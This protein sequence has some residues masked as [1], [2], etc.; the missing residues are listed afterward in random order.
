MN[1]HLRKKSSWTISVDRLV[2]LILS[3]VILGY[4]LVVG[5]IAPYQTDRYYM[6]V[7]PLI[8]IIMVHSIFGV[9]QR[10][11]RTKISLSILSL[12]LLFICVSG[13]INQNINYL[14]KSYEQREKLDAYSNLPVIVLNGAYNWYADH[15]IYEYSKNPAVFRSEGYCDLSIITEA[16]KSH[17]LSN[18]FL[19][20]SCRLNMSEK[21]LFN[22]LNKYTT[23]E[24]HKKI[25]SAGD[26][27][28][29]CY[30]P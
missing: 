15:W 28:Y 20:Y 16:V 26:P 12:L 13:H 4:I 24:S 2:Y 18:G 14:Y 27:V 25:V 5:K 21:E 23:I 6:C 29:L 10:F 9:L 7:Y 17:D 8:Y 1:L 19:I 30:I 11:G 22:E 3:I